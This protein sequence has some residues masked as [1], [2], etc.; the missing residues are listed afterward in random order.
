[1]K[2]RESLFHHVKRF[3][4]ALGRPAALPLALVAAC[5][6]SQPS[7]TMCAKVN[8]V[9]RF[10]SPKAPSLDDQKNFFSNGGFLEVTTRKQMFG[11]VDSYRT[12]TVY[13]EFSDDPL[14]DDATPENLSSGI[15]LY[16]SAH[17]L[18]LSKDHSI[19]LYLF[20]TSSGTYFPFPVRY[21]T[22]EKVK[23][24][25]AVMKQKALSQEQQGK[26]LKA[27]RTNVQ[28]LEELFNQPVMSSTTTGSGKSDTASELCLKKDDPKYQNVCSTYQDLV[29]FKAEL[30][31]SLARASSELL[32]DIRKSSLGR[33]KQWVTSTELAKKFAESGFTVFFEDS[34][35]NKLNLSALHREL[36]ARV[37][38][39][40]KFKTLKYVHDELK[41]HVD[42]CPKSEQSMCVVAAEIA[43]VMRAELSGTK[44]ENFDA[45]QLESVV[46]NLKS[47]YSVAQK[48]MDNI[49]SVF[50]PLLKTDENGKQSLPFT[51]RLHSN[52]RFISANEK[53]QD[54]PDPR[55]DSRAFMSFH[56]NNITGDSS[57]SKVFFVQ[58]NTEKQLGR[59]NHIAISRTITEEMR[60]QAAKKTQETKIPT[61][62]HMG[63]LQAGD[64][65]SIVVI[66]HLPYFAVT[67]VDGQST[68][69]GATIRPLPQPVSEDSEV[70]EAEATA[71]STVRKSAQPSCR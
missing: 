51:A 58:W 32:M 16:T 59:F 53:W 26:I 6:S 67:S 68:S 48:R 15:T 63:I 19:K 28:S 8:S 7:T 41:S 39:F 43:D 24:L 33:I 36:R 35:D 27:F 2:L 62:A 1:M 52:F 12:C 18:D 30:D 71:K 54:I 50:H 42:D 22:L 61:L 11:A 49:F 44:Y 69:G 70:R 64:S 5:S 45:K 14:S 47:E 31:P 38:N 46:D 23:S 13:A 21:P 60:E 9:I 56:L 55:D 10:D 17:C 40:S 65:G 34:P 66:E 4:T 29:V 25:R 37:R 3:S 20:D 57:G